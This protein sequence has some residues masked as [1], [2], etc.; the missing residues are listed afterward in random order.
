MTVWIRNTKNFE[1][2]NFEKLIQSLQAL[3]AM[4]QCRMKKDMH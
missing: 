2:L 1:F 3:T 4:Y